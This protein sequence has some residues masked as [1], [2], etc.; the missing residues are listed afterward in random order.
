M[1][2]LR[3]WSGRCLRLHPESVTGFAWG[4]RGGAGRWDWKDFRV[5]GRRGAREGGARVEERSGGRHNNRRGALAANTATATASNSNSASPRA[6]F[7]ADTAGVI[8]LITPMVF[9]EQACAVSWRVSIQGGRVTCRRKPME[10]AL[11]PQ[12]VRSGPSWVAGSP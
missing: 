1:A 10:G 8:A 5:A 7:R 4:R 9:A 6:P 3:I 2:D 11:G 12:Q